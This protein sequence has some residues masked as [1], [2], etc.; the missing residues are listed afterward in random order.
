[1][2]H[3]TQYFNILGLWESRKGGSYVSAMLKR[4]QIERL[5]DLIDEGPT[6]VVVS[7]NTYK[8]EDRQPDWRITAF[9]SDPPTRRPL[10]P[11]DPPPPEEEMPF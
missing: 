1:M 2:P 7:R 11:D 3:D 10:S 9:H 8:S 4:E 5:L 6:K